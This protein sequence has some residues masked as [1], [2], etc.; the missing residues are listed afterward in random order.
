ME[1]IK[2]TEP[3]TSHRILN[4]EEMPINEVSNMNLTLE[5]HIIKRVISQLE[6]KTFNYKPIDTYANSIPFGSS[7]LA[8]ICITYGFGITN[9]YPINSLIYSQLFLQSSFGVV[10]CGILEYIKGR[11]ALVIVYLFSGFFFFIQFFILYFDPFN[12]VI[13]YDNHS[14]TAYFCFWTFAFF[15]MTM[16]TLRTNI[17]ITLSCGLMDIYALLNFIGYWSDST[18][19]IKVSGGFLVASGFVSYYFATCQLI[20]TTYKK[21]YL[22]CFPYMKN[23]GIDID[24]E[25]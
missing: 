18:K 25:N 5:N 21:N 15:V 20:S 9:L 2:D 12:Y 8:M 4:T 17:I 16:C 10:V 14:W 13:N 3:K 11:N 24:D 23:N 19:T 22:P 6:Q 7:A 1:E